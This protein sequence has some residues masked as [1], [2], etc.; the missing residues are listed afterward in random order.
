MDELP[1]NAVRAFSHDYHWQGGKI[2]QFSLE[3][4]INLRLT[5][6]KQSV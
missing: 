6:F 5:D 1:E 3:I 4:L 2:S